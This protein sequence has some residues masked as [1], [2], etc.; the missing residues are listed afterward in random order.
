[1]VAAARTSAH[2]PQL[3][4]RSGEAPTATRQQPVHPPPTRSGCGG[5]RREAVTGLTNAACRTSGSGA[6]AHRRA[7]VEGSAAARCHGAALEVGGTAPRLRAAAEHGR[8]TPDGGASR[9]R[10]RGARVSD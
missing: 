5:A 7:S 8:Q 2:R 4:A 6:T 9:E 3:Q 10:K 1:M